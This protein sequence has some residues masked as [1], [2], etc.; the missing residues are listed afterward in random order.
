[1]ALK[2]CKA[3]E[4]DENGIPIFNLDCDAANTNWIAASRLLKSGKAEDKK[5]LKEMEETPLYEEVED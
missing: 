5:K 2:K 4:Y 3:V 1:M